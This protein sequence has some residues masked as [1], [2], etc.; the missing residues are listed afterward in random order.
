MFYENSLKS[1]PTYSYLVP[2]LAILFV[3]TKYLVFCPYY[4][5]SFGTPIVKTHLQ[6]LQ[7][8]NG[9]QAKTL[10]FPQDYSQR[11]MMSLCQTNG[12]FQV[13]PNKC[14]AIPCTDDA[15]AAVTP[16]SGI[17]TTTNVGPIPVGN[18]FVQ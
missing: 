3:V 17:F 2:R 1:P 7:A 18:Y 15:I 9:S 16:L 4:F 12:K 14:V 10:F 5:G 13:L 6:Y 8:H 11:S